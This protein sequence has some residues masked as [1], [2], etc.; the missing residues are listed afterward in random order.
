MTIPE[1]LISYLAVLAIPDAADVRAQCRLDRACCS[2]SCSS[3]LAALLVLAAI[4]F[5][6]AR[7]SPNRHIY[8]F[9][10]VWIFLTMA[11]ALNLNGILWL[12]DDRYLYAPS[13]GWSLAVAV[14]AIEIASVGST[15]RNAVGA[16]LAMS[17]AFYVLSTVRIERYWHDDVAYFQSKRRDRSPHFE[18]QL[19]LAAALNRAGKLDEAAGVLERA[20]SLNPNDAPTHLKLAQ[21]YQRLGREMDFRASSR[22]SLRSPRQWPKRCNPTCVRSRRGSFAVTKAIPALAVSTEESLRRPQY[23]GAS[24]E[25][26]PQY[27]A[28]FCSPRS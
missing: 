21:Q 20:A 11:P 8:L 12:V 19:D 3:T 24:V 16:V 14:A 13:F 23:S 10:A 1:T 7:R 2:Q 22:S 28:R 5:V 26:K 25:V 17:L 6:L 27:W 9:C 15:A 4:A 18:Y